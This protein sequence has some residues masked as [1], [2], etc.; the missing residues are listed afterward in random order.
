MLALAKQLIQ[1]LRDS[2]TFDDFQPL[3]LL[4]WRT[5]TSHIKLLVAQAV[6]LL[7]KRF[8]GSTLLNF[9]RQGDMTVK[10]R[11]AMNRLIV[12]RICNGCQNRQVAAIV[13]N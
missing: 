6:S 13:A 11:I 7:D 2:I 8:V 3:R 4:G 1:H 5:S 12:I 9:A 10:Q